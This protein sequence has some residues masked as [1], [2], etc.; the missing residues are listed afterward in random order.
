MYLCKKMNMDKKEY[1]IRMHSNLQYVKKNNCNGDYLCPICLIKILQNYNNY[2]KNGLRWKSI[3]INQFC[4]VIF[5]T[6]TLYTVVPPRGAH[7]QHHVLLYGSKDYE[8]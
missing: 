3:F 4:I 5:I 6:T 2:I 1:Y 8:S 7:P